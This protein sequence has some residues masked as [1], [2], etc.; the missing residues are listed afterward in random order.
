MGCA[1]LVGQNYFVSSRL[2]LFEFFLTNLLVTLSLLVLVSATDLL[3]VYL[4]IEMQSL[5][6][7]I[8]ASFNKYSA[9]STEAGL[10]Y[11]V[12]GA[13]VSGFF[14]FGS[15]LL[16][17][18]TGSTNFFSYSLLFSE[19]F[20]YDLQKKILLLGIFFLLIVFLFKISAAPFHVWSPD[21]YEGAPLSSTIVFVL[22]P[23]LV[24]FLLIFRL[25]YFSFPIFFADF[26]PVLLLSGVLSVLLGSFMAIR[27]KR[28][29]RLLVYSSITH[30][31][32]LLLGCASGT[33]LGL[34]SIVYYIIFYITTN[35]LVWGVLAV[36]H[37]YTGSPVYISDLSTLARTNPGLAITFCLG[38]FSLAGIP[39]LVG[40]SMKFFI[41]QS[42]MSAALYPL[43]W[44]ILML[45]AVGSFYYLRLIK[46]VY[47]EY[48]GMKEILTSTTNSE[49]LY[50]LISFCFFLVVFAFFQPDFPLL[51]SFRMALG[52]GSL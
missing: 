33:V 37:S 6:F 13:F 52:M 22:V 11:F 17:G 3:P 36:M 31:G 18:A 35:T 46:I 43:S 2:N 34:T 40:F 16:Y 12:L 45:S 24:L 23:K 44:L 50:P 42:A 14:L 49:A 39:P 26:Q 51:L 38:L 21:V 25:L 8:L 15:S 4:S 10:K 30:A 5:S 1:L 41:F 29:K 9:F 19:G 20:D 7:Y 48:H 27:Q 28:L 32:F 47:F